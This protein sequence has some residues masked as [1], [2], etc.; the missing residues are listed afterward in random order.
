MMISSVE[1]SAA[2]SRSLRSSCFSKLKPQIASV[3]DR[4][5]FTFSRLSERCPFEEVQRLLTSERI[6]CCCS[7]IL[8]GVLTS[9][10]VELLRMEPASLEGVA[11]SRT[12]VWASTPWYEISDAH[13]GV[14]GHRVG[15]VIKVPV[16]PVFAVALTT[17]LL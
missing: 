5:A 8:F 17:G 12:R 13:S 15:G 4:N 6:C 3:L 2:A 10:A 1:A 7:V 14:E 16:V 9:D 11:A